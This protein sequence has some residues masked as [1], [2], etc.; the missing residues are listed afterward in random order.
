MNSFNMILDTVMIF[1]VDTN[2]VSANS[3]INLK[4]KGHKPLYREIKGKYFWKV[5]DVFTL[6]KTKSNTL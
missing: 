4:E 1:C 2:L 3:L 5:V 6:K